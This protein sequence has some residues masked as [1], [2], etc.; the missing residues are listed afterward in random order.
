MKL[1]QYNSFGLVAKES[2]SSNPVI[3]KYCLKKIKKIL[4]YYFGCISELTNIPK[5]F[6]KDFF[7][8]TYSKKHLNF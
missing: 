1:N 4:K 3:N 2:T 6:E 5:I 7:E 8:N